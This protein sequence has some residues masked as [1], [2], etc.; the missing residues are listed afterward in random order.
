MHHTKIITEFDDYRA[1]FWEA[2]SDLRMCNLTLNSEFP[3]FCS[4]FYD[5]VFL[6]T[7][8]VFWFL[9]EVGCL[10]LVCFFFSFEDDHSLVAIN[11]FCWFVLL[12]PTSFSH[13]LNSE[14][15]P[16]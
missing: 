4:V 10:V 15:E 16:L 8:C 1:G 12:W 6:E 2:P 11:S 5:L 14:V 3:G 13:E 7:F 9:V